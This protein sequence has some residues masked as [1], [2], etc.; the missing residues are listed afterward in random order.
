[1]IKIDPNSG[2]GYGNLGA[3]YHNKGDYAKALFYYEKAIASNQGNSLVYTNMAKIYQTLGQMDKSKYYFE[4]A[5][6]MR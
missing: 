6:N 2:G 1:V 4:K 3:C 5:T